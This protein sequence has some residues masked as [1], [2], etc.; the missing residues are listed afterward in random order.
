[1]GLHGKPDRSVAGMSLETQ[2]HVCRREISG[3]VS[4][5]GVMKQQIAGFLGE[6][7]EELAERPPPIQS[8]RATSVEAGIDR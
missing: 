6:L 4:E 8:R 2:D 1:M 5:T 3:Y 7:A